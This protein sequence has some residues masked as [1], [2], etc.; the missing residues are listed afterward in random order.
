MRLKKTY[1]SR[2]VAAITGLTVQPNANY[3]IKVVDVNGDGRPDVILM[4]ESGAGSAFANQNGSI[5]VFLNLGA[6]RAPMEAKK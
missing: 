3:D 6:T 2:E 4:Y 5:H 1:S